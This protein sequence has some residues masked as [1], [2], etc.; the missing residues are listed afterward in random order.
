MGMLKGT[1]TANRYATIH[2]SKFL[3]EVEHLKLT[4]AKQTI[5]IERFKNM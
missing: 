2:N 4:I 5:E 1:K 3:S